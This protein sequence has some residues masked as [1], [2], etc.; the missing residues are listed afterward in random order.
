MTEIVNWGKAILV[1]FIISFLISTFIV[2]PFSVS[3]RSMEP[4]LDG[5]D[6]INEDKPGDRVMIFKSAYILDE[7]KYNDMVII[8]SRVNRKRSLKDHLTESTIVNMILRENNEKTHWI[9]RVIGEAGDTLE[10][11]DGKIYRNGIELV[12]SYI[13]EEMAFPFETIVVPDNYVF[14]MGDN[15]NGSKD[16]R[17][18]GPVPREHVIGKVIFRYY[19]INK[20]TSF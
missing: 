9:K 19:P 4:T 10:F 20:I 16:S 12:E 2:Q 8:D 18:I 15:R 5:T 3:G 11:N 1:A 14:V 13:K 6:P 17:E 7:P